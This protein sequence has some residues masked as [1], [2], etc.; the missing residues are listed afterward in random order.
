MKN[1]ILVIVALLLAIVVAAHAQT[2]SRVGTSMAQF[3][4]IPAGAR[5]AA[6][7]GAYAA[8]S[9]DVY[10]MAWNPAGIGRIRDVSLGGT[11]N[12]YIADIKYS[13]VGVS[14]PVDASSSFGVSAMFITTD[15]IEIT[16]IEQPN[17]TGTYYD[18]S[19][20][21]LGA[22]YSRWLTDRLTVGATVKMI[23]EAIYREDASTLAFDIGSQFDTGLYGVRLAM[24]VTNFGGK[25]QLDGPDI[26]STS[27]TNPN[28]QGTRD[29]DAKLRTIEWPLPM[30]FRMGIMMDVW[31]GN[32]EVIQSDMNRLTLIVDAND[33]LDHN[34]R[35]NVGVEYEWN[36]LFALRAGQHINYDDNTLGI[37]FG[38]GLK[39]TSGGTKFSIDYA[40]QDF[41]ILNSVH[42]Y[43]LSFY[44]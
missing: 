9:E 6:L 20:L 24:A 31:G 27:N 41:G 12:T 21:V 39:L 28:L 38:G 32:N 29:T 1:R 11:Y 34:L 14:I 43:T 2:F 8:A 3:L 30:I 35:G 23:R 40:Y 16:T 18:Y 44:F 37:T 13:F 5:G 4:K 36:N 7:G 33:P 17:G 26:N 15:P 42:Q 19:G 22:S 10:A 25:M